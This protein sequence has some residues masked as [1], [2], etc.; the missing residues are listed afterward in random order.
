ML[1]LN[2]FNGPLE[3]PFVRN[4]GRKPHGGTNGA[5]TIVSGA[6]ARI[7]TLFQE[8]L[9]KLILL[10]EGSVFWI[11]VVQFLLCFVVVMTTA[12]TAECAPEHL[13]FWEKFVLTNLRPFNNNN[14]K[15]ES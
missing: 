14:N 12:K 1:Q 4:E 3:H 15:K 10:V 13:L 9:S 8:F 11:G 7:V 5:R 6:A 2:T